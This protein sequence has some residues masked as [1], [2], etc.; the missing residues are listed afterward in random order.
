[1]S[2]S[3]DELLARAG[4]APDAL[5]TFAASSAR[6][7]RMVPYDA[8]VRW[9]TA[10][11]T[12]LMTF[13]VRADDLGDGGRAVDRGRGLFTGRER[14]TENVD[15]SR[16]P[17]RVPAPVAGPRPATG[18]SRPA[19]RSPAISRTRAGSVTGCGR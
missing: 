10:P 2:Q 9:T 6:L 13:P 18:D 5:A 11:V 19:V 3:R 17:A 4:H 7:R 14:S 8:A 12:G 16:D 15:L 1:M